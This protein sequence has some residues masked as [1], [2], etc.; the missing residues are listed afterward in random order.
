[1]PKK[2]EIDELEFEKKKDAWAKYEKQKQRK[3]DRHTYV[4]C[5][6]CPEPKKIRS[7]HLKRHLKNKHG[8]PKAIGKDDKRKN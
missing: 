1:M 2:F 4:T 5:P 3:D 8:K 7:D 6:K